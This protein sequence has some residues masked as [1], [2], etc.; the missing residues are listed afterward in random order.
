MKDYKLHKKFSLGVLLFFLLPLILSGC[1]DLSSNPDEEQQISN[2]KISIYTPSNKSEM[3]EGLNE[4]IYSVQ[5]PYSLRFIELYIDG[6]FKQNYPPNQDGTA[7]QI[8]YNFDSTYIGKNIS[9]YLIYYDNNGTSEKSNVVSEVLITTDN[10]IPFKPYNLSL[11]KFNDGS[12][13]ISW[14]DS[15]RYVEKYEIW[16]RI[17]VTNDYSLWQEVSGNSNNVNDYNL[18]SDQIYFYKIRG[19]KKSGSSPFSEEINTAEVYTSGNLMPPTNL[20]GFVIATNSIQ[21]NWIDNSDNENYFAVERSLDKN[22]FTRIAALARN[23][24]SYKDSA[25]GLITGNTYYYRIKAYSNTDSAYS[26]IVE[27]K[28]S[29]AILNPPI[30]LTAVYNST[31]GVIELRWVKTDNSTLFFDIERKTDPN[32]FQL[33]R[34]VDASTT[35]YLDFSI[36]KNKTYTYR[37]R[38]YNLN[39]YSGYSNEVT[40]STN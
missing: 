13:N 6:I 17:G 25:G 24:N 14:K 30:N 36:E 19:V 34:R 16:K 18:N 21:L 2:S 9:L 4:I 37:V 12:I 28:F 27:I 1:V 32:E 10:R 8:K 26:N 5:T 35:L 39:I 29:S 11:I 20:T 22:N 23:T 38:G 33:L 7:P 15:S 31:V 3:S 40:I